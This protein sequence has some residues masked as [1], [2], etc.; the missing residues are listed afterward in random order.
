[1]NQ[2][3]SHIVVCFNNKQQIL[4]NLKRVKNETTHIEE[5]SIMNLLTIMILN[6]N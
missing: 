5:N 4:K 2:N 1:M 6:Y 3:I